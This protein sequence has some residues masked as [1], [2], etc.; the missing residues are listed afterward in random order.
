MVTHPPLLDRGNMHAK[1]IILEY[2]QFVRVVVSSANLTAED[3]SLIGQVCVT[4]LHSQSH[5][6]AC[7][8]AG[9]RD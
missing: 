6:H 2:P 1:L 7:T 9:F 4:R 5:A 3:W 8:H